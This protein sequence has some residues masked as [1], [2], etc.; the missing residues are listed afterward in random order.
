MEL[1]S[2]PAMELLG[3]PAMELFAA[4]AMELLDAPPVEAMEIFIG[5]GRGNLSFSNKLHII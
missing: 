1:V 4:R 3:A 2:A 5:G